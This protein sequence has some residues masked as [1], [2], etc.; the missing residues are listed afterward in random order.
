MPLDAGFVL[1]ASTDCEESIADAREYIKRM[2]LT[3]DDVRL[4]KRDGQIL[5]LTKR[6]IWK[7]NTNSH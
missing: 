6:E 7:S 4:I 1:Y 2:G 5:V 3:G